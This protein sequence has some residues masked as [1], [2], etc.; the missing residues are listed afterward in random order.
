[1]FTTL[2]VQTLRFGAD[3][4]MEKFFNIKCR[5]SGLIPNCAVIV[6]TVRALKMHSG[7]A[8]TVTAGAPLPSVYKE[9]NL[10]LLKQGCSNLLVHIRNAKRYGVE[11][12]VGINRFTTDTPAEVELIRQLAIEAGAYDAVG[13]NHWSQGGAGAIELGNAVMSACKHSR[14]QGTS[15]FKVHTLC[16][17]ISCYACSDNMPVACI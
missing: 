10:E 13:T 15:N 9:E 2:T 11:V 17:H 6:A 3:I 8:P 12:V 4:G 14:T 1:L 16:E 7:N 5:Q